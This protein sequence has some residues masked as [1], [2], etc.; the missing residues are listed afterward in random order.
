MLLFQVCQKTWVDETTGPALSRCSNKQ[1]ATGK[2]GVQA[3]QVSG[4]FAVMGKI[5]ADAA[6]GH[7]KAFPA[8]QSLGVDAKGLLALPI[9]QQFKGIADEYCSIFA[10]LVQR[11]NGA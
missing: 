11:K 10:K 4:T 5:I 7:G 9:D 8:L 2:A 3:D 1:L 6:Q